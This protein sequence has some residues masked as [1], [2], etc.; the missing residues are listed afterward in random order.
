MKWEEGDP[1]HNGS[2]PCRWGVVESNAAMCHCDSL[3]GKCTCSD[4]WHPN[5]SFDENRDGTQGM[6][7]VKTSAATSPYWSARISSTSPD[8]CFPEM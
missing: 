1:K 5:Y 6:S 7:R 8:R 2:K 3:H 4:D